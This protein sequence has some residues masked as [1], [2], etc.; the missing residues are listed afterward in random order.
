M[1]KVKK[2]DMTVRDM[3]RL[4]G[5]ARAAK[6][7]PEQMS[8]IGRKG[9]AALLAKY[10]AEERLE[11]LHSSQRPHTP[12]TPKKILLIQK[13]FKAGWTQTQIAETLDISRPTVARHLPKR[14]R[15]TTVK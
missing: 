8:A 14:K 3:G 11:F 2:G 6:C 1:K 5:L 10:T 15:R 13:L 4:G 7:T 9:T 12:L